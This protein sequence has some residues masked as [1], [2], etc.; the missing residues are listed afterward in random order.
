M[1]RAGVP[2]Q[3]GILLA[4]A[5]VFWFF[6]CGP[7]SGR[8][9][10]GEDCALVIEK[11]PRFAASRQTVLESG[12][13][14][15]QWRSADGRHGSLCNWFDWK[16]MIR[17]HLPQGGLKV[18]GER[19]GQ[20]V[21][22]DLIAEDHSVRARPAAPPEILEI[23]RLISEIPEDDPW[24]AVT[25]INGR[26]ANE[27]EDKN[28]GSWLRFEAGMALKQHNRLPDAEAIWLSLFENANAFEELAILRFEMA[29][30]GLRS[31]DFDQTLVHHEALVES[32]PK[33]F[34]RGILVAGSLN[35][36]G[37]IQ[38][39]RQQYDEAKEY[40]QQ[41]LEIRQ[42]LAP[43]SQLVAST[44]G[45]L[46]GTAL[47]LGQLDEAKE[48]LKKSLELCQNSP[49]PAACLGYNHVLAMVMASQ[50]DLTR[51]AELY[52]RIVE[53]AESIGM[54][55]DIRVAGTL[56]N[57][58][59]VALLFGQFEEAHD[60]FTRALAIKEVRS[61]RSLT[62]YRTLENLGIVAWRRGDLA[63]A[64]EYY[65]QAETLIAQH[66][67]PR[68]HTAL[69]ANRAL[70]AADQG[71]LD[72]AEAMLHRA[73]ERAA[74][75]AAPHAESSLRS[76]LLTDLGSIQWRRGDAA[77]AARTLQ[78]A[79]ELKRAQV[80]ESLDLSHTLQPLAETLID[81][82]RFDDAEPL[83][84]EALHLR[85]LL[86]P[87]S[88]FEAETLHALGRL[89]EARDRP[90]GDAY[91]DRSI[92]ALTQLLAQSAAIRERHGAV[93]RLHQRVHRDAI[94]LHLEKGEIRRA[95][96][97][98]ERW[99]AQSFLVM[100]EQRQVHSAPRAEN[101]E[102][103][104]LQVLYDRTLQ[105][106]GNLNSSTPQQIEALR[107]QL[108]LLRARRE[109]LRQTLNRTSVRWTEVH[110]PE[111]L[112]S[113]GI[114]RQLE[115]GTLLLSY[116][117]DTDATRLF[118]LRRDGAV[119]YLERPIGEDGLH[120]AVASFRDAIGQGALDDQAAA[121]YDELILP[122]EESLKDAERLIIVP[123]GPLHLLPFG[124]LQDSKT[125]QYLV[126]KVP[127]TSVLSGTVY[128]RLR[129]AEQP[130]PRTV[131]LVAFGDPRFPDIAAK[132]GEGR[133]RA[134]QYGMRWTSLPAS[135]REIED[136]AALFPHSRVQ[137]FLAE[138]AREDVV[139]G[140]R[141]TA[142]YLHFATHAFIDER[143]PLDSALVL[144]PTPDEPGANG[145]LQVWE[146]LERVHLDTDMVVL[147]A[148]STGMGELR[149]GE[150][151]IGLT[152]AF[153]IAGARSVLATL[154]PV[155]DEAMSALMVRVYRYLHD[156][157]P[158]DRALQRAQIDFI[159]GNLDI[160]LDERTRQRLTAPYYWANLQLI[161]DRR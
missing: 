78:Q 148:C 17:E 28:L 7:E 97:L 91:Y 121:L 45:N 49:D 137:T 98:L 83:L 149:A 123:D 85:S 93:H 110:L 63:L 41:A 82:G 4:A 64:E 50:G 92:E 2:R 57:L 142:R 141:L 114:A 90:R 130:A 96:N 5:A 70:L 73:L 122:V 20:A 116:L 124:A 10:L 109:Q 127:F 108:E 81:L 8:N 43:D 101:S 30:L 25:E 13:I 23:R 134:G 71:R 115:P 77:S 154:W 65:E 60:Y 150:G 9:A 153:Q 161:G 107:G 95:F 126:E 51:A 56:N 139:S 131:D 117:T 19:Q 15:R 16:W 14:V 38:K 105:R 29:K 44:Q 94:R 89:E 143:S 37:V 151:L 129:S 103:T 88:F 160:D 55:E 86:A 102:L 158:K 135:R 12:D 1:N 26:I 75:A 24:P 156:G 61:P 59:A 39:T 33:A 76:L 99:R 128:A 79:L 40:F 113:A 62:V 32:L 11:G 87:G 68:D 133:R 147:S 120:R 125:G 18:M 58:G 132:D 106:L 84:R 42:R 36:L 3:T 21:T 35:N 22:W 67:L 52:R 72:E 112:D 104:R 53:I 140:Q 146:I 157:L 144:S 66:V 46:A 48:R 152:R 54:G 136:I 74:G 145:L 69:N 138:E 27:V 47:E 100:L 6:A 80:P 31:N 111:T 119:Q 34:Q 159:R 118:A 155:D